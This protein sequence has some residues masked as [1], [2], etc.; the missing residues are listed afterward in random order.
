MSEND[1][2]RTYTIVINKKLYQFTCTDG[3]EHV[4]KLKNKLEKAIQTL[5]ENEANHILSNTAIKLALM[6]ADDAVRAE[7]SI[8]HSLER[9]EERLQPVI[10]D[11]DEVLGDFS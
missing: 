6:L 8:D 4:E 1:Q 2:P 11:L 5:S 7:S 3:A 9:F 10:R